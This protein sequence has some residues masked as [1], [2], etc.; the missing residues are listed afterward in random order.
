[1]SKPTDIRIKDVHTETERI[2]YRSPIKFGGRVVTDAVLL[3]VTIDV[4]TRSGK[5]G[6]GFGSMPMGNVWA[7]P[8][9]AVTPAQ[10]EQAMLDF[11]SRFVPVVTGY[12]EAIRWISPADL[13]RRTN[14]RSMREWFP[15]P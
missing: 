15:R 3:N 2:G 13:P 12:R 11:V 1:M 14:G 4:E 10:S 7:W 5:R 9:G 8:S 6:R